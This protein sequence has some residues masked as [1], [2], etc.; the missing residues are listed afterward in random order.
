MSEEFKIYKS[1]NKTKMPDDGLVEYET[2]RFKISGDDFGIIHLSEINRW[3]AISPAVQVEFFRTEKEVYEMIN[4]WKERM[5]QALIAKFERNE[6]QK[7]PEVPSEFSNF[8]TKLKSIIPSR[9]P[10]RLPTISILDPE[11]GIWMSSWARSISAIQPIFVKGVHFDADPPTLQF[12]IPENTIDEYV[13]S[14]DAAT[15]A[16]M[17]AGLEDLG[18]VMT[19]PVRCREKNGPTVA[20][21]GDIPLNDISFGDHILGLILDEGMW[22]DRDNQPFVA[23]LGSCNSL[24]LARQVVQLEDLLDSDFFVRFDH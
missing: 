20:T 21:D 8:L 3:M 4:A 2:A 1:T 24:V 10:G 17:Y 9:H 16:L 15:H 6:D 11:G 23:A 12:Q 19:I 18:A 14:L 13:P 5:N 22:K 7:C